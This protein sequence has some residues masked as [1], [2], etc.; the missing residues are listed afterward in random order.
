MSGRV[1]A[2]RPDLFTGRLLTPGNAAVP[3]QTVYLQ[4][5]YAGS[6]TWTTVATLR[7]N[8]SGY[9][10]SKQQPKRHT[11]YRFSFPGVANRYVR[12]LSSSVYV[13]Y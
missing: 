5:R 13:T 1:T 3:A 12:D 4:R 10:T 8:S 2:G 9:V 11:Y 7:T 6:T